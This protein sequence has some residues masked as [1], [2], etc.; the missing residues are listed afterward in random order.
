MIPELLKELEWSEILAM[1][2][3][4]I[5]PSAELSANVRQ[6]VNWILCLA[7]LGAT[8]KEQKHHITE[9][10]A[11]YAVAG[12]HFIEGMKALDQFIGA[13]D[14]LAKHWGIEPTT[15]KGHFIDGR[16]AEKI[17]VYCEVFRGI[18]NRLKSIPDEDEKTGPN[19]KPW[20]HDAVTLL[21]D[22]WQDELGQGNR[23]KKDFLAFAHAILKTLKLNITQNGVLESFDRHVKSRKNERKLMRQLSQR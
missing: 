9:S 23:P 1:A 17:A 13:I 14:E 12:E 5:D 15:G 18:D 16:L 4:S 10:F 19:S 6:R 2:D 3:P 7:Y 8:E 20:L 21:Y 11:S 22:V